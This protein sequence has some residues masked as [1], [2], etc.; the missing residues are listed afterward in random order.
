M[1]ANNQD[2][3]TTKKIKDLS[4]GEYFK[5]LRNGQP[6]SETYT[7]GEYNREFKKFSC[8][9]HSDVWGDDV[10]LKGSTLVLVGF[11]Y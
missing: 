11:T 3:E 7:R 9:K 8:D 5:R 1:K 4:K 2:T 10:L 6:T